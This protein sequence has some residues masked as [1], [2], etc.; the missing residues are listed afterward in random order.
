MATLQFKKA[1]RSQVAI[2]I[3]IGGPSG[4]GKTMSSL[5]LAYG[6]LKA[7]HPEWSDEECWDHI[8][9]I[10]TENA[11]RSTRHRSHSSYSL[12][13]RARIKALA[14]QVPSFCSST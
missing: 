10:D 14:R 6:L 12:P 3:G 8:C 11:S 2:K 9:L 1:K 7:E 13:F 4:S 5:L